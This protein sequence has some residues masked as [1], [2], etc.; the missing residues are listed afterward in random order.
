MRFSLN[1]RQDGR[2]SGKLCQLIQETVEVTL[3]PPTHED[4]KQQELAA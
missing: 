2:T 3:Q 4:G 1:F